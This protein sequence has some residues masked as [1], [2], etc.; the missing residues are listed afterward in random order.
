MKI[1]IGAMARAFDLSDEALRYYEKKGLVTPERNVQNGYRTFSR[2]DI[3]RVANIK[4]Y[5]N[6]GFSLEEISAIYSGT[7]EQQLHCLYADKLSAVRRA[8]TY[9]EHILVRMEAAS[10]A[11]KNAPNLLGKPERMPCEAVY[12]LEYDTIEELWAHLPND[13]P[14]RQMFTSLPLTSFTTLIP[15]EA[16]QQP[17]FAI[18][19]GVLAF[20]SDMALLGLDCARFRRIDASDA[21]GVLFRLENGS[22]DVPHIIG[23][24]RGYLRQQRLAAI[25]DLFTVQLLSYLD[26]SGDAVHYSRMMVPVRPV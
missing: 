5:Q 20:A 25:D 8:I 16:L 18:N 6:Q 22:F 26:A 12:V 2:T 17:S 24:L 15:R 4:R 11:L 21:V 7:T 23:I 9:Q 14:L 19:K 13:E 1:S 3:Q 10:A